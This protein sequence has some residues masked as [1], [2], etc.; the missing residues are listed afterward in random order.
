MKKMSESEIQQLIDALK[1]ELDETKP[2]HTLGRIFKGELP[3]CGIRFDEKVGFF[4][5]N[6]PRQRVDSSKVYYRGPHWDCLLHLAKC[7]FLKDKRARVKAVE[8]G[9]EPKT[10]YDVEVDFE[11]IC[12][13]RELSREQQNLA[14]E[15]MSE[16]SNVFNKYFKLANPEVIYNRQT[17]P[18]NVLD[19]EKVQK[20]EE[21]Q[22]QK[23]QS[24]LV[25]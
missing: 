10:R 14:V 15:M 16:I 17:Y 22:N 4:Y 3:Y 7:L 9:F 2:A 18:V 25:G 23:V 1:T 8:Y 11:T 24:S 6:H 13:I 5:A 20:H 21:V 19:K 12:N